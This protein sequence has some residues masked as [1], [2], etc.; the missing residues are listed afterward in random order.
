M[1][2]EAV[3]KHYFSCDNSAIFSIIFIVMLVS[4]S[5]ISVG[6]VDLTIK[7][8]VVFDG[9]PVSSAAIYEVNNGNANN[10]YEVSADSVACTDENGQFQINV[11]KDFF[12]DRGAALKIVVVHPEYAFGWFNYTKGLLG[13]DM[14][15]KL[16]EPNAVSGTIVDRNGHPIEGVEVNTE[17]ISTNTSGHPIMRNVM[18]I[19][20][21]LPYTSVITDK[22]GKFSLGRIPGS[23]TLTISTKVEGYA[24][25]RKMGVDSEA[26]DVVIE[27]IPE[28][29]IEGTV[30]YEDSRKPAADVMVMTQGLSKDEC[31]YTH[32]DGEGKYSLQG[33]IADQYNVFIGDLDDWTAVAAQNIS[34]AEGKITSDVDLVLTKGGFITGRVTVKG[35]GEPVPDAGI[36]FYD[37]ARPEPQAAMHGAFTDK[38]GYYKFRAAPGKALVYASWNPPEGCIV[39]HTA[40][41]YVDVEMGGT[42]EN[43]DFEFE[44]GI[45]VNGVVK[46]LDGEPVS[47]A[48]ITRGGRFGYGG[49][50][51]VSDAKGAFEIKGLRKGDALNISVEHSA[52]KLRG[53]EELIAE[54]D[55]EVEILLEE[56]K[57]VSVKGLVLDSQGNPAIG[58][59]VS[60]LRYMDSGGAMSS[61][62]ATTDAE[63]VFAIYDLVVG[64]DY[65]ILAQNGQARSEKFTAAENMELFELSL[66]QADR[67]LEG[68]VYDTSG[69]P[70]PGV[71]VMVNGGASGFM[72]SMT[73][74]DGKYRLDGLIGK[75]E[76]VRMMYERRGSYEFKY[77]L[78]NQ[79]KDFEIEIANRW[80]EGKVT[81][82][83]GNPIEGAFVTADQA[84]QR[85]RSGHR[86]VGQ[87]TGSDGKFRLE[88]LLK[89]K[90][91]I[92][93]SHKDHGYKKI[94]NI[95]TNK[96]DV[97]L[98]LDADSSDRMGR[99][100]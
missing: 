90:E 6:D 67:W 16:S 34:A 75:S 45:S 87:Q 25:Q 85:S 57:T 14:T 84:G 32:T 36:G 1:I 23:A 89:E 55:A 54:Q 9:N 53:K 74:S 41:E 61:V 91:A 69:N 51:V 64:N 73:D 3:M 4:L 48:S 81:D 46:T 60:L 37:A 95:E 21:S 98:V 94:E 72:Q 39:D 43:I 80:L 71:R 22:D 86:N 92:N 42:V 79:V 77:V 82:A 70:V 35:T 99:K 78:T 40:R 96:S 19:K 100:P 29:I 15:I 65:S 28:G 83:D 56:Y 33:L 18:Y 63:G 52:R 50:S 27:L 47:G 44:K 12:N 13:Q 97:V 2:R 76:N 31:N 26:R 93:I 10:P 8:T 66:P 17:F 58:T 11:E 20:G 30:T 88:G 7:G 24:N 68:V 49:F 62:A 59:D 38:D 5:G